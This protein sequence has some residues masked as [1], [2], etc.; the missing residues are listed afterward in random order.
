MNAVLETVRFMVVFAIC[1][2]G[3]FGISLSLAI[4]FFL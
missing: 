3:V 1:V 2:I 4:A